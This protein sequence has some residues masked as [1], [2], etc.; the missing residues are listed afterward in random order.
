MRFS[1]APNRLPFLFLALLLAAGCAEDPRASAPALFEP[2]DGDMVPEQIASGRAIREEWTLDGRFFR[3]DVLEAPT[4]ATRIGVLME[5][6]EGAQ[7]PMMEGRGFDVNGEPGAWLPLEITWQEERQL[8]ARVDLDVDAFSAQLRVSGGQD[9]DSVVWSALVPVPE[10]DAALEPGPVLVSEGVGSTTSALR[11]DLAAAGVHSRAEWGARSTSCS[12]NTSKDRMAIHH[13]V[14]PS[15][16]DPATRLRGIQ[17]FHIDTRG[18]CDIGYHFLV[19][20]DGR[21]WEGRPLGQLGTHVANHNTGNIG[22]SFIGCFQ[23]SGCNDWTPFTPPSVMLD[24]GATLVRELSRI[25]GIAINATNVKGHRDHSG[26]TTSCPGDNLHAL[27]PEIRSRASGPTGPVWTAAYVEQSF[28]LARDPFV[29]PPGEERSG[30]IEMR[31]TGTD[32]WRPGETFLGT[33]NPRDGDSAIAGSDWVDGHR[34]ATIDRV[35]APGESGRFTFSVRAPTTAGDY[36]Q[37]FNLVQEG[38]A[39]FT[40]PGD[41][42]LQ[43]KVTVAMDLPMDTDAGTPPSNDGG[44]SPMVDA[45]PV[46]MVDGG[47]DP[48]SDMAIVPRA[49]AGTTGLEPKGCGCRVTA[50]PRSGATGWL[51]STLLLALLYRR[52]FS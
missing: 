21:M 36:S 25:Y 9:I 7:P 39:W 8:V 51:A 48:T 47:V 43:I 23:N 4:G 27:L 18:W 6:A 10:S 19:S 50:S 35:V 22:I 3:S 1:D 30:Y 44:I 12:S 26:A 11:S 20:L 29:I 42:Q 13:T 41:D 2:T 24:G 28:P 49:D 34:A 16:S 17:A 33:T 5:L 15:S 31:N 52:R 46:A 38:V 45:G 14:T 40:E 32:P 37:Y